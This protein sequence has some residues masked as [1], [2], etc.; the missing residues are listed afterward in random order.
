MTFGLQFSR[1][2]DRLQAGAGFADHCDICFG[3][4]QRA[5]APAHNRVVVDHQDANDVRLVCHATTSA[6]TQ[7]PWPGVLSI[8]RLPPS[9]AARSCML[10]RPMPPARSSR[11]DI[12][13]NA[14]V[15]DFQNSPLFADVPAKH[16]S[17]WRWRV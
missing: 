6:R 15:D 13:A 8:T 2:C 16:V 12:E 17:R 11:C 3:G 1:G 4:Q 7:V 10:R 9:L 5:N 14:I